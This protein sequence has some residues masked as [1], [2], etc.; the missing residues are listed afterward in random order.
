[1]FERFT[2]RARRVVVLAQE[3]ARALQHSY[4]GTEHLLLGL[5]VEADGVGRKALDHLGITAADIRSD[6]ERVIGRGP[7]PVAEG[8]IPFTPRSK[9]SLE[10][11]LRESLQLTHNYIGTEHILLGLLHLP[12]GVAGQILLQR[13]GGLGV[14]RNTVVEI[15][16]KLTLTTA[17]PPPPT[18]P[19]HRFSPALLG[20]VEAAVG[21]AN[22][23]IV[24]THHVLSVLAEWPDTAAHRVLAAGGFDASTLATPIADWDVA[25]TRDETEEAWAARV[26][27]VIADDEGFGIL[28]SDAD[29]AGRIASAIKADDPTVRAAFA[30]LVRELQ[31]KLP[32]GDAD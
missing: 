14:V 4:I 26:T 10:A 12:E 11:A 8:H 6:I 7:S 17:A 21:R 20:A 16:G 2:D 27:K 25:D 9:S 30:R 19:A 3:E 32:P 18:L 5:A 28:L 29:L 13:A 24:G 22:D 15:L 23:G 1:M 31:Q